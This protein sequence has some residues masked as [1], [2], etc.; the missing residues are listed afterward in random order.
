[1]RKLGIIKLEVNSWNG[2]MLSVMNIELDH[3]EGE[4]LGLHFSRDYL[5]IGVLFVSIEVK[6]PFV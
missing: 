5:I 4:L 1:M 2:F 3:F 6:S